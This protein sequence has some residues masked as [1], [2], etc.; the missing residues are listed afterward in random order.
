VTLPSVAG[1]HSPRSSP[2]PSR[3]PRAEHDAAVA[4]RL[5]LLGRELA[6]VRPPP[7]DPA[8]EEPVRV[9]PG[10]PPAA[11]VPRPGRHASRRASSGWL[12]E[13]LRGRVVLGPGP[14]AVVAVL[15]AVGLAVT[16]WWVVRSEPTTVA[17]VAPRSVDGLA[18]PAAPVSP[19]A[20]ASAPGEG[21]TVTVD[22]AGKVRRPG[23]VVL[24]AGSRV[25][26]ALREAGGAR[27]GADTSG[28]NLARVLVDGE[29]VV[30]GQPAPVTGLPVGA[31]PTAGAPAGPLVDLNTADLVAL[32]ALPE[33]GP[34][35]AQAII[36]WRDANGGFTAVSELLE[37]DGIGDATLATISPFVT[38]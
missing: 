5:E 7:L 33:V 22:V 12:P 24:D 31:T 27:P 29:Q 1:M 35:T 17:P 6:A 21:G 9:A 38:V 18:T 13:P 4:R 23:I 34:V 14:L 26:D 28:L 15:V 8:D 32:E 25:V 11:P 10:T 19:V 37:V 2:L 3:T 16:A 30:V 20:G 36:T